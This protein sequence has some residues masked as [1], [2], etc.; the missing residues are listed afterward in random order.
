MLGTVL[1]S[2]G[3]F[4]TVDIE[5]T[6]SR[7]GRNAI[8]EIGA[9]R[10]E[11]RV[12]VGRFSSLV[13]SSEP[14]PPTIRHLTGIDDSMLDDAPD[15]AE[16]MAAFRE[17]SLGAVLVAHNH[18]FDMGFL[19]Y[20]AERIWGHPFQRPVLD[21]LCLSRCLQPDLSQH[22]L[23]SLAAF[24][25]TAALPNH[26]AFPDALAT[27]EILIA[28]IA[29]LEDRGFV[30]AAETADFCGVATQGALARKLPLATHLPD[31]P[32]IY[33]FRD[34]EGRVLYIGR[35]KNLRSRVRSHF[36]APVDSDAAPASQ[37]VRIDHIP[38]ASPLDALLLESRLVERYRPPYNH[39]QHRLREPVFLYLDDSDP[40]PAFRVTRRRRRSGVVIGPLWNASAAATLADALATHYRLRRCAR[41]LS[42]C[43]S[44]PCGP[45]TAA[46]CP[47]FASSD[48]S[49]P[50]YARR[51]RAAL[52]VLAGDGAQFRTR[53]GVARD[54]AVETERYEDAIASRDA[55]RALDR[56]LCALEVTNRAASEDVSVVVEGDGAHAVVHV[57]LRG[58]RFTT[59]RFTRDEVMRR[60]HIPR[61][62]CA[63]RNANEH[64][65]RPGR[66]TARHLRDMA[67]ID[68]YRQEHRP[69]TVPVDSDVPASAARVAAAVRR[70]LRIPR[71][72]HGDASTV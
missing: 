36:Y 9:V 13:R 47:A 7:P 64:V 58:R 51:I 32:G 45:R 72:R 52:G 48:L 71:P 5:T 70:S 65:A 44:A 67:I 69:V 38:C 40:L 25:G 35:A 28:M 66:M 6:G 33:L 59:L 1:L 2:T 57:V 17:F 46:L 12:V 18:R 15:V 43:A 26:R 49:L 24:Y 54:R 56:T 60:T 3:P 53:L 37:T 62:V 41:P 4:V 50:A 55:I 39:H 27:A 8:I 42:A 29:D 61:L 23:G 22:N 21:T 68:S 11:N 14:I 20:E 16:V 10:I 19:D 63:L 30:T 34:A 31:V